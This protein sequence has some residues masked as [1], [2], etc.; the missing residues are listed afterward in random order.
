ML[1]EQKQ[2]I[3]ELKNRWYTVSEAIDV[4]SERGKKISE[5]AFLREVAKV[6]FDKEVGFMGKP[7]VKEENT[8][9]RGRPRKLYNHATIEAIRTF[10]M[11]DTFK[12]VQEEPID[13]FVNNDWKK[14]FSSYVTGYLQAN[15]L[16]EKLDKADVRIIVTFILEHVQQTI[17][18]DYFA[19]AG[20]NKFLV[21]RNKQLE[22]T[23]EDLLKQT[24]NIEERAN[25]LYDLRYELMN[26]VEVDKKNIDLIGKTLSIE[27]TQIKEKLE[28]I[29]AMLDK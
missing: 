28:N 16:N 18:K 29:S 14:E 25:T 15:Y 20:Q 10:A 27:Y 6:D 21:H 23:K 19:L 22:R 12:K 3:K 4:L 24:I 13:F 1:E 8:G 7:K 2:A 9:G 11:S 5:A 17:I 26:Y